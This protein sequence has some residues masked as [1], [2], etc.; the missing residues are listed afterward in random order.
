MP[1]EINTPD[2]FTGWWVDNFIA[3]LAVFVCF[4]LGFGFGRKLYAAGPAHG[5]LMVALGGLAVVG[6]IIVGAV[7]W[8][9]T[10]FGWE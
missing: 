8:V 3:A 5:R 2:S 7:R 9:L 1:R 10:R 4:M 6:T